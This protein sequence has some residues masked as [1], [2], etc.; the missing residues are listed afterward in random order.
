MV[1]QSID[2]YGMDMLSGTAILL[3]LGFKVITSGVD[4]LLVT[5]PFMYCFSSFGLK[6]GFSDLASALVRVLHCDLDY[7]ISSV[8][9]SCLI[10]NF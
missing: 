1:L 8:L 3:A 6:K 5:V 10:H 9:T 4:A 7:C 2:V